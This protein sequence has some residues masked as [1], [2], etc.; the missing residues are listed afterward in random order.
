MS[1]A[2]ST[3]RQYAYDILRL[4]C[5]H[6]KPNE[7]P[8]V[9]TTITDGPNVS[10]IRECRPVTIA[11]RL[12]SKS[13]QLLVALPGKMLDDLGLQLVKVTQD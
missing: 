10:P 7:E 3:V 2:A 8:T 12:K 13:K 4:L 6:G 5:R 11:F 9:R 1:T